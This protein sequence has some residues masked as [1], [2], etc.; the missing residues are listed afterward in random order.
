MQTTCITLSPDEIKNLISEGIQQAVGW[1][2]VG[3]TEKPK[4]LSRSQASKKYGVSDSFLYRLSSDR[5][6]STRRVGKNVE[7]DANELEEHF[8]RKAKRSKVSIDADLKKQGVFPTLKG[9]RYA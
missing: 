7:F 9:N 4:Y 1:L 2:P 5:E 8:N 6:V 3:S